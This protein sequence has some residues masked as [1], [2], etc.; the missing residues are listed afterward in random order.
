MPPPPHPRD[1]EAQGTI[2]FLRQVLEAE[3][4]PAH[5][6]TDP[7]SVRS[8]FRDLDRQAQ[9][10][11]TNLLPPGITGPGTPV[12]YHGS[13]TTAHGPAL[14]LAPCRCRQCRIDSRTHR[15]LLL[16]L[17]RGYPRILQHAN[18]ASLTPIAAA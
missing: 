12:N 3:S 15:R 16:V 4:R 1:T 18:T 9:R 11:A 13:I 7:F 8:L 2:E 5:K 17:I 10:D 14:D 6:S